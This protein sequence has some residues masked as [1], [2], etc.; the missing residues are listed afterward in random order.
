MSSQDKTIK[1]VIFDMDG[2]LVDSESI[3]MESELFTCKHFG[4]ETPLNEWEN[5]K[6][7]TGKETF[8]YLIKNYCRF[9]LDLDEVLRFNTDKYLA[10]S[11]TKLMMF[12]GTLDLLK[13]SKRIFSKVAMATSGGPLSQAM[14]FDKFGFHRY[15]DIIIT[16]KDIENGK[17]HPEPY[18][19]AAELTG[20]EPEECIV[21]EDSV[22]GVLSGKAAGCKVVGITS[23]FPSHRLSEAGADHIFDNHQSIIGHFDRYDIAADRTLIY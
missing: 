12:D 7:K 8:S 9:A 19:K 3:H 1:A 17:P 2:V 11:K 16:G 5:F 21:V 15:F 23:S 20:F 13:K 14:V 22:N 18:L 4:I 6:G 10:L